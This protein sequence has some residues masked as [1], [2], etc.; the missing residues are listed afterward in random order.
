MKELKIKDLIIE[1]NS[2]GDFQC[3]PYY[4]KALTNYLKKYQMALCGDCKTRLKENPLRVLDCKN[5]KCKE[6]ASGA[7]QV[8]DYLCEECHNH[9]KEVLEYLDELDLPYR[10]NPF[11]V[12]GLDYYTKTVFEIFEENA[13]GQKQGTL[14]GGGRYDGLIKLLG[15]KDSPAC[16]AAG[17]AERIVS[18]MKS[19]EIKIPK[20]IPSQIFLTQL[21]GLAKKKSL[22]L[23]E[24]FRR[25]NIPVAESLSRDSLK[26]QLRIA[27]K[28]EVKHALIIG[29]KEALDETVIIREMETGKQETVKLDK[30]I[31]EMKKKIKK[32]K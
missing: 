7:H 12:R 21:G 9:F 3:R 18:I 10:L 6:I 14:V 22:K 11:L 20:H 1:I 13:D 30:V 8:I 19:Q 32:Q 4:K 15:G 28:L 23:L 24:E 26:T 17:G 29:Q 27:D 2:I 5:E 31:E 16:G 25:A